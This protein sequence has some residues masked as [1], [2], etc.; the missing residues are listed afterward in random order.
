MIG[1]RMDIDDNIV[2]K[3]LEQAREIPD[4]TMCAHQVPF[5]TV[6]SLN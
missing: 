3:T 4:I 1:R 5:E 2:S 6:V